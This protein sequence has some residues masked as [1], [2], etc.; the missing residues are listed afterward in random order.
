MSRLF[1]YWRKRDIENIIYCIDHSKYAHTLGSLS[2][3]SESMTNDTSS[4]STSICCSR[5]LDFTEDVAGPP[6]KLV[7]PKY[8]LNRIETLAD[9]KKSLQKFTVFFLK[10]QSA[11]V[12]GCE[13]KVHERHKS[14][15]RSS[16]SLQ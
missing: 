5:T 14:L 4:F 12:Q 15:Q 10:F 6:K 8:S 9:K 2:Q 7:F 11:A 16:N 3:T 1:T 13:H